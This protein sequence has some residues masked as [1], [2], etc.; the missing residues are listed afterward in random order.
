MPPYEIRVKAHYDGQSLVLDEPVDLP[1]NEPLQ[2][3]VRV[4]LE[5]IDNRTIEERLEAMRRVK[6]IIKG[7]NIPDAA[8]VRDEEMYPDRA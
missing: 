8:F 6:G 4:S 5:A 1:V 2:V 3:T 7:V